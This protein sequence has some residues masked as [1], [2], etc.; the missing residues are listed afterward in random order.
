M[1]EEIKYWKTINGDQIEYSKLED[2]HLLNILRVIE[3]RSKH[4]VTNVMGGG[5]SSEG[6]SMWGDVEIITGDRALKLYDYDGLIEEAKK[7]K[8]V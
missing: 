5:I 8:L 7:R 2:S 4:G 1:V 6:D 3:T